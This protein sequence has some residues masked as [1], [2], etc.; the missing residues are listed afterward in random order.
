MARVKKQTTQGFGMNREIFSRVF[1]IRCGSRKGTG[2]SIDADDRQYLVTATH[3]LQELQDGK[4]LELFHGG[5]WKP[6]ETRVIGSGPPQ[7]DVIILALN[8]RITLP[9]ISLQPLGRTFQVGE[10][11]MCLGFP[12]G[13]WKQAEG[14]E[15][16]FPTPFL[17]KGVVAYVSAS[18]SAVKCV[19][20]D[21]V[22]N[23]GFSGGPVLCRDETKGM[24]QVGA[25]MSGFEYDHLPIYFG[26][27]QVHVSADPNSRDFMV[28]YDVKQ[29]LDIINLNPAGFSLTQ[30]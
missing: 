13:E 30:P 27:D 3:L 22:P 20:I 25:I 23:P 21:S 29:A 28:A 9:E 2:F 26:D 7:I 24:W 12:F 16:A 4:V 1:F 10:E 5:K 8:F 14:A 19:F 6:L 18:S 11:V 17:K 15:A